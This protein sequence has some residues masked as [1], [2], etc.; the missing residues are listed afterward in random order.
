MNDGQGH[1][2]GDA[3]LAELAAGMKKITRKSDVIG[4]IGGDEFAMFLKDLPS[5]SIAEDK[6]RKLLQLFQNLFQGEK[7]SVEVTCSIGV[8]VYPW[9]GSSYQEL[10]HCADLALYQAKCWGK[11]RYARFDAGSMAA[12]D[13]I[14]YSSLGASIDSDQNTG[15]KTGDLVNYVFQILYLSL[16]HISE[17][18]RP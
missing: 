7:Q 15:G 6:A 11:N 14:G 10:Y 9:D 2:F 13:R 3:V 1:L 8:A 18:T 16:I 17:P 4:R 5:V 12:M